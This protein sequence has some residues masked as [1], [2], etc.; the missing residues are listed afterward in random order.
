MIE[1]I[2]RGIIFLPTYPLGNALQYETVSKLLFSIMFLE[3]WE[4]YWSRFDLK[5]EIKIALTGDGWMIHLAVYAAAHIEWRR[6]K[7]AI[8]AR[9]WWNWILIDGIQL[10][11]AVDTEKAE[12]L[13][14]KYF[15][16]RGASATYQSFSRSGRVSKVRGSITARTIASFI[17]KTARHVPSDKWFSFP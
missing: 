15:I 5:I 9:I 16:P 3:I 7:S 13:S 12:L 17:Y 14:I 2:F 4:S 8:D 11:R 6:F 10:K 1:S